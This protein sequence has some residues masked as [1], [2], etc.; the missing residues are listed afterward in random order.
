MFRLC[1]VYQAFAEDHTVYV[2]S[3]TD[4]E[5]YRCGLFGTGTNIENIQFIEI[6][7]PWTRDREDPSMDE[8]ADATRC[9]YTL[10]GADC[11]TRGGRE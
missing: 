3:N 6:P 2:G 10:Y 9:K 11:S 4:G 8:D 5:E 7:L 1:E